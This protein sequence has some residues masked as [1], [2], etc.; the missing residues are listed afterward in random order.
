MKYNGEYVA[1]EI[2]KC[3][4]CIITLYG[5]ARVACCPLGIVSVKSSHVYRA[6]EIGPRGEDGLAGNQSRRDC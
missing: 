6:R 1:S 2:R 3:M 5:H 4:R